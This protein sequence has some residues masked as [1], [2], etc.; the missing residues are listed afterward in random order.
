[1]KQEHMVHIIVHQEKKYAY[2]LRRYECGASDMSGE[3]GVICKRQRHEIRINKLLHFD[4]TE[5]S[6]RYWCTD[7]SR[8][9]QCGAT[10][11]EWL[12]WSII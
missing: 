2:L 1:M 3:P 8:S 4:I 7:S 12:Y 5:V 10:R 11:G 9:V 6:Y